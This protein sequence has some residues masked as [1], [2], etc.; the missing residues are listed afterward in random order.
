MLVGQAAVVEGLQTFTVDFR[1][2]GEEGGGRGE[3]A[4]LN[5]LSACGIGTR[6]I[7]RRIAG[8]IAEGGG[9]F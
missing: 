2:L 8:R 3:F 6:R 4:F 9:L 7:F 1:R 5:F